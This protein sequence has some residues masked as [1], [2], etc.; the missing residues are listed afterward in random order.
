MSE[1]Y[2][3]DGDAARAA[4]SGYRLWE[5]GVYTPSRRPGYP[6]FEWTLAL[7]VP[8]GRHLASNG[9]VFLTFAATL[10]AMTRL[11]RNHPFPML[12]V[13]LL[14]VTPTMLKNAVTTMDYMPALAACLW[15]YVAL[16]ANHLVAAAI[17]LGVGIG[18]RPAAVFFL[19]P[20]A[21]YLVLAHRRVRPVLMFVV[22]AVVAGSLW[23]IPL[24]A[25]YGLSLLTAVSHHRSLASVILVT[26]F[27]GLSLLGPMATAVLMVILVIDARPIGAGVAAKIK[28]REPTVITELIAIVVF[29]VPFVLLPHETEYLLPLVPFLFLLITRWIPRPAIMLL[30]VALLSGSFVDLNLK[31]GSSGKR[32]LQLAIGPGALVQDYRS[33]ALGRRIREHVDQ[34]QLAEPAV[35]LT[36]QDESLTLLN[37]RLTE[38]ARAELPERLRRILRSTPANLRIHRAANR[39]H[40]FVYSLSRECAEALMSAGVEVAMF[41]VAAPANTK[42]MYGYD[43]YETSIAI[44]PVE[45]DMA[46]AALADP[47]PTS[48]PH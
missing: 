9:F 27:K 11:S 24:F 8:W 34:L 14:A 19:I 1:G 6:A 29:V 7:L 43:P 21:T 25:R 26:G 28:D 46:F 47:A 13:L 3:V 17:L 33:R 10:M 22:I 45:G 18:C 48:R 42:A 30:V 15:A 41:A 4:H 40:Y 37:P 23:F 39:E 44:I 36:G 31:G 12:P 32:H 2:G 5:E 16:R 35:I 38:V 20:F